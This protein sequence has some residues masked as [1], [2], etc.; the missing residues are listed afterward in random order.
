MKSVR[1]LGIGNS[2][3][4]DGMEYVYDIL[5]SLGVEKIELGNLHIGGCSLATH[6]NN[7]RGDLPAYEYWENDSGAWRTTP[8]YKMGDAIASKEWDFIFTQQYSGHSGI[9]E[10]YSDLDE[11]MAYVK[12]KQKGNPKYGWQMTW[13]YAKDA[14]HPAFVDYDNDQDKMYGAIVNAV[15]TRILP[16]GNM[17]VIPSGTAIQNARAV[18]GDVLNRDGFHLDY[19]I[20]RYIAGLCFVK[21][22]VGLD[23]DGVTFAPEGVDEEKR[24]LAITVANAACEKPFEVTVI[25]DKE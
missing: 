18:M 1:I 12:D 3:S 9:A 7:L 20:G 23:I 6:C 16:R 21:S 13:S 10:T 22:L 25:N 24:R 8:D 15:Q 14:T 11:L 19:A 17:K 4:V 5:Y 2:F